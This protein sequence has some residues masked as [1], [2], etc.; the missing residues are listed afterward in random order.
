MPG[1]LSNLCSIC[2]PLARCCAV[3]ET[4]SDALYADPYSIQKYAFFLVL[5]HIFRMWSWIGRLVCSL[6]YRKF[7][8]AINFAQQDEWDTWHMYECWI[9]ERTHTRI[10]STGR[11]WALCKYIASH[12]NVMWVWIMELVKPRDIWRFYILNLSFDDS[13][14]RWSVYSHWRNCVKRSVIASES[15]SSLAPLA[16]GIQRRWIRSCVTWD[17]FYCEFNIK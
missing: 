9:V 3:A 14:D 7:M 1:C 13:S 4:R 12:L 8:S 16:S 17:A 5:E 6:L 2:V 10:S 11:H 15:I